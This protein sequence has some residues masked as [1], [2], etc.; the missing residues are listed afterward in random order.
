MRLHVKAA[1]LSGLV[2]PGLGQLYKGNKVKGAVL[3]I[4]VNLFLLGGLYLALQAAGQLMIAAEGGGKIVPAQVIDQLKSHSPFARLL[5]AS[6]GG[7]WLYGLL[8]AAFAAG[9]KRQ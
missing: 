8:D 3:I 1:L 9:Q 2:L 6:F 5:L 4:C 7:L